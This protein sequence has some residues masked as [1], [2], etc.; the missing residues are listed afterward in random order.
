MTKNTMPNSLWRATAEIIP[1]DRK[2][3]EDVRA[4]VTVIGAGFTGLS[5]ALHLAESGLKVCVLEAVEPGFGA[6]G[7]NGGQIIPGLKLDPIMLHAHFGRERGEQIVRSTQNSAQLVYDL[8]ERFQINCQVTRAGFIQPAFSR[9]AQQLIGRR[10]RAMQSRNAPVELLTEAQTAQLLGSQ[11]YLNA[12]L[13]RRGGGLQPLEYCRGL[14]LAAQRLGAKV[15]SNSAVTKLQMTEGQNWLA[16]S[17]SGSVISEKLLICTNGYTDRFAEPHLWPQLHK[18]LV[19]VYSFQIATQPLPEEIRRSILPHGHVAS[20][21]RRLLTYFRLD[22]SGRLVVGGRGGVRDARSSQDYAHIKAKIKDIYPQVTDP[23]IEYRW[24]G[25]V[26]ITRDGLPHIYELAPGV[27][28]GLGFN[29]RGVAMATLM[30][31]WLAEILVSDNRDAPHRLPVTPLQ[32]IPLH[33][34]R[35]PAIQAAYLLKGLQDEWEQ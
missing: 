11:A 14:A 31:R 18:T 22:E 30:G 3:E 32:T 4:D 7:R 10:A 19:P 6:S 1:A 28:T 2:L 27:F 13:D 17:S 35:K 25:K 33:G 24:S 29:G 23:K 20:D 8:I 15:Y 12:L 21:T 16:T 5:A 9:K 34:L 26:A